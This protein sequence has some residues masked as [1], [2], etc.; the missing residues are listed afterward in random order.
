[1]VNE[2]MVKKMGWDDPLG[3]RIQNYFLSDGRVI[4][5]VKDFH[6]ASLHNPIEPFA[7]V[8]HEVDTS[9][10]AEENRESFAQDLT[11]TISG[12]DIPETIDFLEK[13]FTEFDPEHPFQFEFMDDALNNLYL[14]DQRMMKLTGIFSGVC[15]FISCLGLLGLA[16]FTTEQRTKEIGIRKVLGASTWQIIFLLFRNILILVLT[17]AAL[18]S[19]A[20]YFAMDEWLAGFAYR[21]GIKPWV[22]LLSA[23]VAALVA[24]ATV[25]L[26]SYKTARANP[27]K[28]LRYE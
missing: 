1:V 19:L 15:I 3:K 4:G 6:I 28:A 17:G 27:V 16:S 5:V 22:F 20:A 18:A 13:K 12:K 7:M 10:I 25:A 8:R 26:Q 2:A 21:T 9:Q 23:L 11:L 24:F 14:S